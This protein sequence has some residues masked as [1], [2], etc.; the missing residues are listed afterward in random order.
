MSG[1]NYTRVIPRDL[2]NEAKLLKC[3]GRLSLLHHEGLLSDGVTIR[4]DNDSF[5]GFN[6]TQN[7]TDGSLF[8]SN[9]TI[10]VNGDT[11]HH[12]TSLNDKSNYPLRL[13]SGDDREFY[14]FSE[15]GD[16]LPDFLT[17]K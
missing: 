1:S 5:A 13:V 7:P 4:H 15:D 9:L 12:C 14:V 16:V 6:I 10:A 3:L 2:F 8:V 11:Y 17:R